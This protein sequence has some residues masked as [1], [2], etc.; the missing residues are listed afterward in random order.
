MKIS[1]SGL[2]IREHHVGEADRLVT[3][4][5]RDQG[6]MRAFASGA[7][8]VKGK[9]QAAT[10]L[11]SYGN[12]VFASSKDAYRIT[13]AECLD[14][15]FDLRSD[16]IKLS[17]AQYFCELCN[18]LAPEQDDAS[19]Y[20]R[21]MLNGLKFLEQGKVSHFQLK[22]VIELSLMTLS[23]YMPDMDGCHVCE[24]LFEE[25]S[26]DPYAGVL[27]CPHHRN[28]QSISISTGVVQAIRH[29]THAPLNKVF[30]FSLSEGGLSQLFRVSEAF[31]R[32]QLDREFKTL[33]F[34]HSLL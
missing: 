15:F 1:T 24:Q 5:T 32:A 7:R 13:E 2:I 8:N 11:L 25:M 6:L 20:L 16:L 30:F 9:K 23:G 22:S 19:D 4:L 31:V 3:V 10:Q 18:Y 14:V 17:L 12:Y 21:L 26:F 34:Y 28:G 27:T 29:I 33:D